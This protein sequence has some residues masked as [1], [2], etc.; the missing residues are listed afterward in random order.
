MP[1]SNSK[2]TLQ[3]PEANMCQI[4]LLPHSVSPFVLAAKKLRSSFCFR[5]MCSL[6]IRIL[7]LFLFFSVVF[8]WVTK[9]IAFASVVSSLIFVLRE[10]AS[11]VLYE[12]H[13]FNRSFRKIH[14]GDPECS[15]WLSTLVTL[16]DCCQVSPSHC[17]DLT[18]T[19]DLPQWILNVTQ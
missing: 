17:V 9:V 18:G 6:F 14:L 2:V 13:E 16:K 15:D 7:A 1:V 10:E 12:R 8:L 5:K 19:P 4:G 11:G 3:T